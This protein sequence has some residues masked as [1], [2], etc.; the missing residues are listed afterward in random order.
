MPLL[1]LEFASHCLNTFRL[2]VVY[3]KLSMWTHMQTETMIRQKAIDMNRQLLIAI[4][5]EMKEII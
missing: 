4:A 5:C 2:R 1:V 3:P